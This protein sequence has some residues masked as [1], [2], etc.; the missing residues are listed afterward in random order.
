MKKLIIVAC[1]V[2]SGCA[3]TTDTA[4][5]LAQ[6]GIS[7]FQTAVKQ[8]CQTEIVKHRYWGLVS[9]MLSSDMQGRVAEGVCSCVSEK[10]P[11]VISLSEVAT[12]VIDSSARPK[13]VSKAVTGSLQACATDYIQ[14]SPFAGL[15]R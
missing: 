1:C 4:N 8:K 9:T 10:T 2:L 13:I 15:I 14:Q 6:A 7:M 5:P 11:Q 3:T 12:A